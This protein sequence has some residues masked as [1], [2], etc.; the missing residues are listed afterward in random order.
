MTYHLRHYNRSL[1]LLT[2]LYLHSEVRTNCDRLREGMSGQCETSY[3]S[4][5]QEHKSDSVRNHLFIGARNGDVQYRNDPAETR[6]LKTKSEN[7]HSNF[8]ADVKTKTGRSERTKTASGM[9][10]LHWS[11]CR[12]TVRV[13][14]FQPSCWEDEATSEEAGAVMPNTRTGKCFT[15]DGHWDDSW[16]NFTLDHSTPSTLTNTHRHT[17]TSSAVSLYVNSWGWP[18]PA[19]VGSHRLYICG[20]GASGRPS[21]RRA[22]SC[23]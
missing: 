12:E 9:K 8:H 19:V 11:R 18:A 2:Y 6:L 21:R 16:K 1:Y 23:D 13:T 22:D 7:S 5:P 15:C 10:T 20:H 4:R 17:L 3:G 14:T